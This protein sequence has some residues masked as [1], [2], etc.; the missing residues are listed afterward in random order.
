[1]DVCVRARACPLVKAWICIVILR[2]F[3]VLW[4]CSSIGLCRKFCC[5]SSVAYLF[6]HRMRTKQKRVHP[7]D[8]IIYIVYYIASNAFLSI[9]SSSHIQ[10]PCIHLISLSYGMR[11]HI[12][13]THIPNARLKVNESIGVIHTHSLTHTQYNGESVSVQILCVFL[14]VLLSKNCWIFKF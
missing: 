9:E 8:N 13:H 7:L 1:M 4:W 3:P 6:A 5:L 2:F 12:A 11:T 14:I 10:I